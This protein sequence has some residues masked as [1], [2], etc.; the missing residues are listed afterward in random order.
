MS[1]LLINELLLFPG[2]GAHLYRF[3]YNLLPLYRDLFGVQWDNCVAHFGARGGHGG[4]P[5]I[6]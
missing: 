4:D 1:Q 2:D 3:V 5:D 6:Q